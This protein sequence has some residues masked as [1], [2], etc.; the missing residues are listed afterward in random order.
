MTRK[1]VKIVCGYVNWCVCVCLDVGSLQ[2]HTHIITS[3]RVR[4]ADF[5]ITKCRTRREALKLHAVQGILLELPHEIVLYGAGRA[6]EEHDNV[7]VQLTRS[8]HFR[9]PS[10]NINA[11]LQHQCMKD[12]RFKNAEIGRVCG[13]INWVGVTTRNEYIYVP[14]T[15]ACVMLHRLATT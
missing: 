7:A 12:F 11:Y 2:T 3:Q 6:T 4:I 1:S 13:L 5:A 15:A 8:R 14:I 10:F 9:G